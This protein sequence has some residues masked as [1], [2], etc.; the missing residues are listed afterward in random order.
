MHVATYLESGVS[1]NLETSIGTVEDN[2]LY[3]MYLGFI[4]IFGTSSAKKKKKKK[5]KK[6]VKEQLN[7]KLFTSLHINFGVLKQYLACRE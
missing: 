2:K 5:K 6:K 1:R 3:F 4:K 7:I